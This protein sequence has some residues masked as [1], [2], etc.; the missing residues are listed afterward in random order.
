[1]RITFARERLPDA[2]RARRDRD[3]RT[4]G[5]TPTKIWRAVTVDAGRFTTPKA[6]KEPNGENGSSVTVPSLCPFF[7]DSRYALQGILA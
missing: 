2:V 1:M 7:S 4:S 5:F 6:C 3:A